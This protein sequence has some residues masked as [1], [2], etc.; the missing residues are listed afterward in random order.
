METPTIHSK[1]D[2]FQHRYLLSRIYINVHFF[3]LKIH[4][5][6]R[7]LSLTNISLHAGAGK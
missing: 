6:L 5:Y 3:G 1:V 7:V 2:L 4:L